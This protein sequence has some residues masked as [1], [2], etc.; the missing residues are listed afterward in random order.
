M[1][2]ERASRVDTERTTIRRLSRR[3]LPVILLAYFVA[4]I[5]RVNIGMIKPELSADIGLTDIGFGLASGLIFIGLIFFEIPSNK[6]AARFGTRRW[7]T[8]IMLTWG[9]V[10]MAGSLVQNPWQLYVLRIALG[11]AEAGMA[12]AVFLFL[13]QWFPGKHRARALSLFFL[14][15]PIA[16]V[17]GSPITGSILQSAHELLGLAGWRWVF[18]IEGVAAIL[19]APLVLRRLSDTPAK[20]S[21]LPAPERAWLTETFAAEQARRE[22]NTPGTFRRSLTDGRVWLFSITYLLLGYGANALVYWMPTI[23][24][25]STTALNPLQ[26]GIISAIPFATAA[27]GIYVTGR[28][29]ERTE[30][31]KWHVL[32][33][34]LVSVAGFGA[35]VAGMDN[36]VLAIAM[37]SVAL[38][39]AYAAQPQFWTM[40]SAYLGG[41]A[42]AGGFALIN[43]VN[44]IGGFAAPYSFGW[45]EQLDGAGSMLPFLVIT[46][47]Q[48]LAGACVLLADRQRRRTETEAGVRGLSARI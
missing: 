11:I 43:A 9:V 22:G 19:V 1:T 25:K 42:A 17:L 32:A 10:V 37:T 44:N 24:R 28:L 12:P 26:I 29:A 5:D 23:I 16:M 40:P 21:W 14:S 15:V 2:T 46:V 39:G 48:L 13:A 35:T 36:A 4:Y 45:L 3:F 6:L 8:R 41:A 31:R 34:V 47:T 38:A 30:A 33:P 27:V 20:A 18:L 7:I